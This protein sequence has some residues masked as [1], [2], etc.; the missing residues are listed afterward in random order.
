[1][2]TIELIPYGEEIGIRQEQKLEFY[3]RSKVIAV[4]DKDAKISLYNGEVVSGS[5]ILTAT[6]QDFLNP[7][8]SSVKDLM[9]LIKDT[10]KARDTV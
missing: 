2:G 5:L 6:T 3:D 9:I 4:S 10:L 1:M 7:K 8:E